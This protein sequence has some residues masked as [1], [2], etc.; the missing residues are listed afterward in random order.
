MTRNRDGNAAKKM[1]SLKIGSATHTLQVPGAALLTFIYKIMMSGKQK[2]EKAHKEEGPGYLMSGSN[3][4]GKGLRNILYVGGS[5]LDGIAE[6]TGNWYR[7]A[8]SSPP[9][10]SPAPAGAHP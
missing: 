4:I 5:V 6:T 2:K 1:M 7:S 10:P 9:A 8:K 3:A